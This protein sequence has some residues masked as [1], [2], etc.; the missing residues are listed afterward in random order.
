MTDFETILRKS[1]GEDL[2]A[3][4]VIELFPGKLIFKLYEELYKYDR[5]E[6]V[7]DGHEGLVILY[8]FTKYQGH[9]I[10][11]TKRPES[12]EV[13]DSLAMPPDGELKLFPYNKD[14]ILSTLI[15]RYKGKTVINTY[16]FQRD[17]DKVTTC[18]RH[19]LVRFAFREFNLAQ[20]TDFIKSANMPYDRLVTIMSLIIKH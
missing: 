14:P 4:D 17:T 19:C 2:S 11:L 13:F 6:D 3:N 8:Q 1:I 7:F 18:G 15:R 20:F 10:L 9:F 16:K 12:I 5:L